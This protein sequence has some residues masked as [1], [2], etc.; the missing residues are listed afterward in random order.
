MFVFRYK[1]FYFLLFFVFVLTPFQNVH[2]QSSV[3][4]IEAK[5]EELKAQMKQEQN[6]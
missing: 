6:L 1:Y 5:A 4:E 3:E 2:S